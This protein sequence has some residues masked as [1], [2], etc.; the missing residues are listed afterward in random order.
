[1]EVLEY[2]YLLWKCTY[3]LRAWKSDR[4]TIG[5]WIL[6]L[7]DPD[8]LEEVQTVDPKKG[9]ILS[10]AIKICSSSSSPNSWPVTQGKNR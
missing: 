7:A 4:K 10:A 3:L 8:T 9:A 1:M 2:R 5:S 6:S